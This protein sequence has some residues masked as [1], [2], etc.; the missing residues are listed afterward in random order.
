MHRRTSA[1]NESSWSIIEKNEFHAL[2]QT[3]QPTSL[4]QRWIEFSKMI[5]VIRNMYNCLMRVYCFVEGTYFFCHQEKWRNVQYKKL[6]CHPFIFRMLLFNTQTTW[7][8][9]FNSQVPNIAE[10]PKSRRT[11]CFCGRFIHFTS[12]L[13]LLDKTFSTPKYPI[14]PNHRNQG[15]RFVSVGA[16]PTSEASLSYFVSVS[17]TPCPPCD[18]TS[19]FAIRRV[20]ETTPREPRVLVLHRDPAPSS[21]PETSLIG[22]LRLSVSQYPPLR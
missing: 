9:Y 2:I 10:P 7:Y 1:Q 8:N 15:V 22:I 11:L 5:H 13:K 19:W 21:I 6:V 12:R 18:A 17:H 14:L 3:W 4:F 16:L 20:R